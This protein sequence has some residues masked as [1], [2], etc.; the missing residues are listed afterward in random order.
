MTNDHPSMANLTN[1]DSIRV[2][3]GKLPRKASLILWILLAANFVVSLNE[4]VLGVALPVVMKDLHITAATGQWLTTAFLLTMS[5]VIPITGYLQSRYSTRMLFFAA[6][7]IFTLGTVLGALSIDFGVLLLGRVFQ[8]AGTALLFPM[9]MTTMM[10]IVPENM[11]GRLM[12]RISL[13]F[14]VAP[15]LGPATS[16]I[17]VQAFGWHALFWLVLPVAV[18]AV[19][20]GGKWLHLEH[21]PGPIRLDFF[22]LLLSAVGFSTLIYGLSDVGSAVRASESGTGGVVNPLFIIVPGALVV[23]WFVWRQIRLAPQNAAL[24]DFAPFKIPAFRNSMIVMN[25]MMITLF[26]T[27]I[28]VPIYVQSVLHFNALTTG[29]MMMPG[30]LMQ[31]LLGVPAGRLMDKYSARRVLV[32]AL[33]GVAVAIGLM[34]GFGI[35]TPIWLVFVSYTLLSSSLAFVFPVVMGASMSSVGPE[36]YSHASA[37][38]GVTQQ[39]FGA[40]GTAGF[41]AVLTMLSG[42]ATAATDAVALNDGTH[43]A[44]VIGAV[45][46]LVTVAFSFTIRKAPVPQ[47]P[48]GE[49]PGGAAATR[50]DGP[51]A[52]PQASAPSSPSK[53]DSN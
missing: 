51:A 11:R 37:I 14:A 17:I 22:S 30:G 52:D 28:I 34:A 31:G 20:I 43:G 27:L 41:V 3:K 2:A 21:E 40:A 13:V 49:M 8:A 45:L 16:G 24:L 15:A 29:L 39:V 47:L 18:A 32:P 50:A 26:G 35:D 10:V 9:F 1:T 33:G 23:T 36:H 42:G 25:L 12:G 46:A 53:G 19:V 4:T 48:I 44:F 38:V 5:V 7:G 6:M